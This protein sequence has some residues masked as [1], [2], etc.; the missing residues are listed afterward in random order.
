MKEYYS[1]MFYRAVLVATKKA[2]A[3]VKKRIGSRSSAGFLFLDRPI[4]DVNVEL[5][6]PNVSM[7]PSLEDVQASINR[8]C[9]SILGIA[10]S[11]TVWATPVWLHQN[12]SHDRATDAERAEGATVFDTLAADREIVTGVLLLTGSMEGAKRQ[13]HEYLATF[14]A[15]DW[16]WQGNKE[17]E[18]AAFMKADP[19]L[20]D[21]ESEIKKYVDVEREIA[22]IA[23][24]HNIGALSLE[25]APLK[26]SLRSE[27]SSWKASY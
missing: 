18:Y 9:R 22:H 26:Y 2:L 16:L 20:A 8:S 10:K 15:Y 1:R 3:D 21:F 17:V 11:L 19:S 12:A 24:V 14:R 5:S 23:P 25:T 13:V 6:I 4:F 27:A 7:S